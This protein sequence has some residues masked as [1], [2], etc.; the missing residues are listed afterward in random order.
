ILI[1]F[2]GMTISVV[3]LKIDSDNMLMVEIE[4]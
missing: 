4:H 1:M 3:N 2:S